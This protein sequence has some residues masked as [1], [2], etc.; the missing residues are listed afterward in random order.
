MNL[1]EIRSQV[2]VDLRLSN[3]GM[4]IYLEGKDDVDYLFALLGM[5]TPP[6]DSEKM[7]S[8]KAYWSKV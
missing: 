3:S 6:R 7:C 8:I 2:E 4:V 1:A 5:L